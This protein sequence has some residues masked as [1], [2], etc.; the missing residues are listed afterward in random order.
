MIKSLTHI[1]DKVFRGCL[2][3]LMLVMLVSVSWQVIS[4]YLLDS[5]SSWTEELARFSL[6]WIAMLGAA[7]AYHVKMHLGLDLLVLKLTH[8]GSIKLKLLLHALTIL[9]ASVVMIYGGLQFVLMTHE[10]KQ[11]SAAL[12]WPMYLVYLCL[13]LSG[14]MLVIYAILDWQLLASEDHHD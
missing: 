13:P 5:P 4:R 10:L 3:S 1:L 9:F 14:V 6:I 12:G 7:Y 2:A 11:Y 8:Q